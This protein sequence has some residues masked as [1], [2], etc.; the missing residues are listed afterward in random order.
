MDW[1]LGAIFIVVMSIVL[2]VVRSRSRK[3]GGGGPA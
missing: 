1:K 2:F 3:G